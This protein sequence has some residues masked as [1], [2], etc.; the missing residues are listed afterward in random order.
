M[1]NLLLLQSK[2]IYIQNKLVE[3]NN[4]FL[5]DLNFYIPKFLNYLWKEPELVAK[6]LSNIDNKSIIDLLANFFCNKFY[7]N[8]LSSSFVENNLLYIISLM[9]NKEINELNSINQIDEFLNQTPCGYILSKLKSKNDIQIFSKNVF[10][11]LIEKIEMTCSEKKFNLDILNLKNDIEDL[12]KNLMKKNGNEYSNDYILINLDNSIELEK[13][14]EIDFYLNDLKKKNTEKI[15]LFNKKYLE[16]LDK[17]KFM[18]YAKDYENNKEM[19]DYFLKYINYNSNDNNISLFN[20]EKFL[21]KICKLKDYLI[22]FILYTNDFFKI[23]DLIDLFIDSFINN[24]KILPYYIKCICKIISILIKNKFPNIIKAE[25]NAFISKFL[26]VNLFLPI[27]KHPNKIYIKN[28]LISNNIEHNLKLIFKIFK[29]LSLGRLYNNDENQ[30]ILTPFNLYFIEKMPKIFDLYEKVTK[31]EIPEFIDKLINGK[32]PEN[33]KYE[34]FNENPDEIVCHRSICFKISDIICLIE[35]M[36]K[37]KDILFSDI[38]D[39]K[40]KILSKKSNKSTKKELYKI[41]NKLS[42]KYYK[43]LITNININKNFQII[44]LKNG[45][46]SVIEHI[47]LFKDLLINPKFENLFNVEQK[48]SPFFIN[49]LNK[50]ENDE[51]IKKN[52][53]IKAKNYLYSILYGFK[54]LNELDFS[55]KDN[56]LDILKEIKIMSKSTEFI[57]DTALP[58]EWYINSLLDNLEKIPK[59]LSDNDY[60]LF[61]EELEKDIIHSKEIIDIDIMGEFYEKLEN[62]KKHIDFY[63]HVKDIIID[64]NLSGKVKKI[65]E[66]KYTTIEIEFIYNNEEKKFNI[67]YPNDTRDNKKKDFNNIKSCSTII[68][69]INS[70]PDLNNLNTSEKIGVLNVIKEL[71]IP[72]IINDY[73]NFIYNIIDIDESLLL[74]EYKLI[75]VKIYEYIFDKLSDKFYPSNYT[76]TDNLI[77]KNCVKLSWT[78]PMH[79]IKNPKNNNFD[80]FI[81]DI[82]Q[83]FIQFEKEKSPLKKYNIIIN[84]FKIILKFHNFNGEKDIV[85]AADDNISILL[86]IFTKIMPKKIHSDIE[87][88]ELFIKENIEEGQN[89]NLLNLKVACQLMESINYSHLIGISEQ[90]FNQ[91]CELILKGINEN[92]EK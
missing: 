15:N 66:K 40:N 70:F 43:E 57:T 73:I 74:D 5:Q 84:I 91:N 67:Y 59:E 34:Y 38:D 14:K 63:N 23:I 48:S 89:N 44:I 80:S 61:Y 76:D 83:S 4:D 37:C 69:F 3:D 79:F 54:K 17:N 7:L 18:K 10:E 78:E 35:N 60:E 58:Y 20:T 90:E 11:N 25:V 53:I 9:L 49:E 47:L 75:K 77:Y 29:E 19:K 31:I 22:T 8:I 62:A 30:F 27:F 2:N 32:L 71:N 56:I 55:E 51:D 39:S 42:S 68:E 85:P 16:K 21:E 45:K 86:Y 64:T 46:D 81:N 72:K 88:I 41:L 65:I 28:F 36:D 26:F 87:Y 33:Y 82:K 1:N 50:I 52:N 13:E 24:M 6:L 12:E 92:K